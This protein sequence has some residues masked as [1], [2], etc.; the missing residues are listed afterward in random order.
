MEGDRGPPVPVDQR[1]HLR[2]ND[3]DLHDGR[4]GHPQM[5]TLPESDGGVL[6][7]QTL[8]GLDNGHR[9]RG[10]IGVLQ[11][12]QNMDLSPHGAVR[13]GNEVIMADPGRRLGK[14]GKK[15]LNLGHP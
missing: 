3:G 15:R 7:L 5:D 2:I 6:I 9:E 11:I 1:P 10:E 4:R 8:K 12:P 14:G 13:I